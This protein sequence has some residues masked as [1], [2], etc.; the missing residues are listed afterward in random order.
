MYQRQDLGSDALIKNIRSS[1]SQIPEHRSNPT[2]TLID[3]LMSGFALFS[4][5]SASLLEFDKKRLDDTFIQNMKNLYGIE[6]VPSDSAM[7]ETLDKVEPDTLKPAFKEVFRALQRG[8]CLEQYSYLDNA[9]LIALDGTG[10]FSSKT[11]HCPQCLTKVSKATGET[12]Y[13]HQ[14][15][16]AVLIHPDNKVVLPLYPELI[17]KQDGSTKNDCERNAVKRWLDGFR[18]DHPKLKVIITEDGLSSNAPHIKDLIAHNC[19]F[20]LGA[21]PNDHKF[22]FEDVH[23]RSSEVTSFEEKTTGII[24]RYRF[25]N[26][27]QLNASTDEKVN[28][29]E[30]TEIKNGKVQNFTWVTDIEITRDNAKE[31]MRGGRARWKIENETFNTLKNQGYNFEHNFGHGYKNLSNILALLMFLAF[32]VDQVQFLTNQVFQALKQKCRTYYALWEQLRTFICG[33]AVIPNWA[34]LFKALVVGV[35]VHI[36]DTT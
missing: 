35:R 29:I 26:N 22:L 23:L 4:T 18:A 2:I 24:Q 33:L 21:K 30:F 28:F 16:G 12:T 27:V 3:N 9:Y 15:V 10:Y 17:I 14:M 25:L 8:K 5:K 19:S 20:I 34:S 6:K 32:A 7:R 11:V 1:F 31:I 13:H 36:P